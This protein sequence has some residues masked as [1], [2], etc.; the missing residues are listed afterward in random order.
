[1]SDTN[2]PNALAVEDQQCPACR[3]KGEVPSD[4]VRGATKICDT[5]DGS[6]YTPTKRKFCHYRDH[7]CYV[8][9]EFSDNEVTLDLIAEQ[10]MDGTYGECDCARLQF[11]MVHVPRAERFNLP[12]ALKSHTESLLS[13]VEPLVH[14][15]CLEAYLSAPDQRAVME[16]V[17]QDL[18]K[19]KARYLRYYRNQVMSRKPVKAN[20]TSEGGSN[21]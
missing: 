11:V 1:M 4:Y 8:V 17:T 15:A 19:L 7:L 20:P 18:N 2:H 6:G 5:C 21:A 9:E 16:S 3:G 10:M 12:D 14:Q 13:A